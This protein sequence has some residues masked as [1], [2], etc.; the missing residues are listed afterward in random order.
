VGETSA[1]LERELVGVRDDISATVGELERRAKTAVDLKEQIYEHPAL[2]GGTGLAILAGASLV[3]FRA[4][5]RQR[6][7]RRPINRWRR[8]AYYLADD[9]GRMLDQ[10]QGSLEAVRYGNDRERVPVRSKEKPGMIKNLLW[11]GLTAGALAISG[12][13]A[14][15]LC[16]AVWEAVMHEPP[17]TAKV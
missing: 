15:R 5:A 10:T 7:A 14:R 4:V 16:T 3:A 2:V 9:L 8:R 11:M 13:L 12:L 17:P 6:E 1:E